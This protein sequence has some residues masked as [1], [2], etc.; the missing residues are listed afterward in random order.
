MGTN[1]EASPWAK[2]MIERVWKVKAVVAVP[3]GWRGRVRVLLGGYRRALEMQEPLKVM[4]K[5]T[6]HLLH[7]VSLVVNSLVL[8]RGA[9]AVVAA[10]NSGKGYETR[11]GTSQAVSSQHAAN[12]AIHFGK[13]L[14][15]FFR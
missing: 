7:V 2:V 10:D 1:P 4:L 12:V 3:A 6:L 14:K 13:F 15:R 8:G 11:A 5:L 9:A